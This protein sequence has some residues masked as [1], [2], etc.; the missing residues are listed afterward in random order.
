[1]PNPGSGLQRLRSIRGWILYGIL[2]LS[3]ANLWAAADGRV[4]MGG[5]KTFN[6]DSIADAG[7]P[8]R[9]WLSYPGGRL[10]L[11]PAGGDPAHG[12]E[13]AGDEVVTQTPAD[14]PLDLG[15]YVGTAVI[16]LPKVVRMGIVDASGADSAMQWASSRKTVWYPYKL[17]IEA[18]YGHGVRLAGWDAFINKDDTLIRMLEVRGS[19]GKALCL[20]GKIDKNIQVTWDA[21]SQ[22]LVVAGK[23]YFY[24]LRF[25]QLNG[26]AME[27]KSI[28]QKPT[29][30]EAGWR[31][32]LPLGTEPVRYAIGFGFSTPLQ[33]RAVAL[34][35]ANEAFEHPVAM[36]LLRAKA[37]TEQFLRK[38]PAPKNWGFEAVDAFGVTP[39]T[40]RNS[41]Y[42]AW[43][44]L[45]QSIID[46]LP[47]TPAFPYPQMS[48]GKGALWDGGEHTSPAT[49]GWES[50]LGIQWL[51]FVD[52]STAWQAYEGIMSRVDE[53]G[54]LGGESLPSRKAQTAW[55]LFS[56][57]P[58]MKRLAVVYPA[59]KRYLLW[60][61]QN[62][63]WI[64]GENKHNVADEKD[65][66]FVV[67]WLIDIEYAARIA[68]ALGKRDEAAMWRG[69]SQPMVDNM[70]KWFFSDPKELHQYYF[71]KSGVHSLTARNEVRPVMILS[72]FGIP[73]LPQEMVGRL[74]E[75]FTAIH[76]P[77]AANDGF[78]YLKYPDNDF[79]A[80][81]LIE[82]KMP[83][84]R[85][86]I[87]A[88]TR[89]CI[90]S[91]EFAETIEMERGNPKSGGV[92]PSLFN[93]MNIIEFTW[94][95][96]DVR[97]DSGRP[98]K[99]PLPATSAR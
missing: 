35:R 37:A 87:E 7:Q 42:M 9:R 96:N 29:I 23:N 30:T 5:D 26:D 58:D 97:Y 41:Y 17:G 92:K 82:R 10:C 94:L 57:K 83:A 52:P 54:R 67:S 59:I 53:E 84:A 72:A 75:L 98:T 13:V 47:E 77:A 32:E 25:A 85:E 73:N 79:L 88:V 61:E 63:R 69:K 2:A 81:G 12:D 27:V 93:P 8:E 18:D 21:D 14:L 20:T 11:N 60:R 90:R 71:E 1:M 33:G 68:E 95:M 91:G 70:G 76:K 4:E 65:M 44:F 34:K 28:V 3:S 6:C 39:Q 46:A 55:V 56:Q 80:Y 19:V 15:G 99:C 86:F 49:C 64:W 74:S 38:V 36:S 16:R 40:H 62:P 89:D 78:D 45:Y 51:S 24:A 31:L 43:T 48:L 66:E 50:F 22:A